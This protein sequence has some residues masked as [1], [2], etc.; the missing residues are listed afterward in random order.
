MGTSAVATGLWKKTSPTTA[1]SGAAV[2]AALARCAE[3]RERDAITGLAGRTRCPVVVPA[4]AERAR[5]AG[6]PCRPAGMRGGATG[7]AFRI[8]SA[9]QYRLDADCLERADA[10]RHER[11]AVSAPLLVVAPATAITLSAVRPDG[12]TV[13]DADAVQVRVMI[14]VAITQVMIRPRTRVRFLDVVPMDENLAQ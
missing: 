5:G 4:G 3:L 14:A 6:V 12:A 13:A 2:S 10:D 7:G 1:T 8:R 11:G 9:V